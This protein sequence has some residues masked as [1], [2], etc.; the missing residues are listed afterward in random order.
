MCTFGSP[1]GL[2][3]TLTNS[4]LAC[5]CRRAGVTLNTMDNNPSRVAESNVGSFSC[6]AFLNLTTYAEGKIDFCILNGGGMRAS[7]ARVSRV[8]G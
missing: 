6:D 4:A 7:I 8:M 1:H 2:S 5:H 3:R